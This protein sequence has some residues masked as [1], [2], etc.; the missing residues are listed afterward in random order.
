MGQL[1]ID[2]VAVAPVCVIDKLRVKEPV[3][4][5]WKIAND[6]VRFQS[7]RFGCA[8]SWKVIQQPFCFF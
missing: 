7:R 2:R 4:H 3:A 5:I 1:T 8:N 6:T